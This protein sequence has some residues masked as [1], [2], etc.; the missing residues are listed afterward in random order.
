MVKDMRY[1]AHL[2]SVLQEINSAA[3]RL[4]PLLY[5]LQ[6]SRMLLV[7][8]TGFVGQW[9][10][11]VLS[12]A[13]VHQHLGMHLFVLT[14]S[15]RALLAR[16]PHLSD[17]TD[18]TLVE[19]DITEL[20]PQSVPPFDIAVHG[21]NLPDDGTANW[22]ARHCATALT[23]TER[24]F[25]V[26]GSHGCTRVLLL[27]SGAVYGCGPLSEGDVFREEHASLE[28][29]LREPSLY[30]ETKRFLEL[31]A[32]ALG[33]QYGMAVPVARCFTFCG[34]YLNMN[35]TNA[36]SSF[37][38]DALNGHDIVVNGDGTPVRS[39][40]HGSDMAVWL[41][42]LLAQGEHGIAYNVGSSRAISLREL[43]SKV[44]VLAG[45]NSAVRVMGKVVM[46][47]APSIYVPDTNRI[48]AAHGVTEQVSLDE[49][50]RATLAW[51]RK[52]AAQ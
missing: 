51:L 52:K 13:N 28:R 17:H 44:A 26:A 49:G 19:G 43:A 21:A 30:G 7:G 8:C 10:T 31:Y 39:F 14:R 47:N 34:A 35:V 25:R 23:G 4:A 22:A 36:L 38:I 48:R 1:N 29:R 3:D 2:S 27:S 20:T 50:L 24:L 37:L 5:S 6:G 11:S 15:P 18:V 41:L 33:L 32:T 42:T 12:W 9:L 16:M 45:H 46:G 40:M